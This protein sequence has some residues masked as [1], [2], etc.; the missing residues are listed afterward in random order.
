MKLALIYLALPAL[1]LGAACNTKQESPAAADAARPD[2]AAPT[3][4]EAPVA[5]APQTEAPPTDAPA[6]APAPEPAAAPPAAPPS[7]RRAPAAATGRGPVSSGTTGSPS[8]SGPEATP[9]PATPAAE[10][11]P[12][13]PEPVRVRTVTVPADTPLRLTLLTDVASDTSAVEDRVSARVAADVAVAGETVIP[14]G[15]RVTGVVT[16]AEPSGKVKGRAALTVRFRTIT[17]GSRT[18]DITAEPLRR[19]ASGTKA[20]DAGKIGI[21]A[22]A[23]AI[24]GG[25]I[26]GRKGAGI[27]AAVGGAGA[28]GV[29]LSTTGDEVRLASGTA[30]STRLDSPLVVEVQP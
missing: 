9:L 16:Y 19:V 11:P 5:P 1:L 30:I 14:A 15:S 27:G 23:G 6:S 3:G 7:P 25:I 22:G 8:P 21:G 24:V 10:A 26:G 12:P 29:V 20:K 2:A 18:Y 17:I 4:T 28:T 13:A